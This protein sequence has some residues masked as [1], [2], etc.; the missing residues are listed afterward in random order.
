QRSRF[1]S[2]EMWTIGLLPAIRPAAADQLQEA[3]FR[4]R[5]QAVPEMCKEVPAADR[6]LS[7]GCSAQK[8]VK[9][10]AGRPAKSIAQEG[11]EKSVLFLDGDEVGTEP[12]RRSSYAGSS[13]RRSG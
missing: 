4:C 3:H 13:R 7:H 5:T 9:A 12:V 10:D 2:F 8:V 6:Q 11:S 1:Q